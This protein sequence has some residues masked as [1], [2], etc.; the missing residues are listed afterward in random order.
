MINIGNTVRDEI[1]NKTRLEFRNFLLTNLL[2]IFFSVILGYFLIFLLDAGKTL[3]F[4]SL[5]T[6][7]TLWNW[8]NNFN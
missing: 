1:V 7:A 8:L 6:L 4:N 2:P 5:P 3:A